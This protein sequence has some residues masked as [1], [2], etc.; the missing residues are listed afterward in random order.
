[1]MRA[2][3]WIA[4]ATVVGILLGWL[5]FRSPECPTCPPQ[6]HNNSEELAMLRMENKM[7]V[8]MVRA[9]L[10]GDIS[11]HI[12]SFQSMN[13]LPNSTSEVQSQQAVTTLQ[14]ESFANR[15]HANQLFARLDRADKKLQ[16]QALAEGWASGERL[17]RERQILWQ[18]ARRQLSPFDYMAALHQAGRPNILI[19]DSLGGQSAAIKQGMQPGD[20]IWRIDGERVLTRQ[21]YRAQLGSMA[22]DVERVFELRRG[23]QTVTVTV[24]N[25][26]KTVAV[27]AQTV[28]AFE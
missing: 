27:I 25:P 8:A 26:N 4:V 22:D 5:L 21:E 6:Q 20:I 3:L 14:P 16:K 17:V 18:Q 12:K 28:E 15:E 2:V 13:R 11:S 19:I 7:L 10:S 24:A 9:G 1:M 23:D